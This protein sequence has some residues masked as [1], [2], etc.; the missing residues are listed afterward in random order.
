MNNLTANRRQIE[1][2]KTVSYREQPD[3]YG[4]FELEKDG[5]IVYTRFR[6]NNQLIALKPH[7]VGL[8]FFEDIAGFENKSAFKHLFE[9]FYAGNQFSD[10]FLF[11]CTF[12]GEIVPIRV[13]MLKAY[14]TSCLKPP[15]IVILDIREYLK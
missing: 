6:Q 3:F 12:D 5:K 15:H 2:M 9:N 8:N 10:N 7:L 4:L 13:M 14:S 1:K 11:D